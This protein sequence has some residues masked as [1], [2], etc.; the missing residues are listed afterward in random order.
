MIAQTLVFHL[1]ILIHSPLQAASDVANKASTSA[2]KAGEAVGASQAGATD[3]SRKATGAPDTV[4]LLLP[5][6]WST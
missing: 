1:A 3:A 6:L 2:S 4:T 5:A